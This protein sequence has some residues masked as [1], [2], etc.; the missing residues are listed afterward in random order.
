MLTINSRKLFPILLIIS[1]LSLFLVSSVYALTT[2][3][4]MARYQEYGCTQCHRQGGIADPWDT[5]VAEIKEWAETY[6]SLDAAVKDKL[7]EGS[8]ADLMGEMASNVG[9]SRSDISDLEQFFRDTFDEAKAATGGGEA[10]SGGFDTTLLLGIVAVIVIIVIVV[11]V[12]MR[13]K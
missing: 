11:V 12:F 1:L 2:S 13:R 3:E 8:F 4:A 7:H 9:K 6:P 10:P 5:V